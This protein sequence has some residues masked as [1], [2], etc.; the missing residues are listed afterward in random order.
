[1]ACHSSW[2]E[3][4]IGSR[5]QATVGATQLSPDCSL[6][7]WDNELERAVTLPSKEAQNQNRI[8]KVEYSK[9]RTEEEEGGEG[10]RGS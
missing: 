2:L 9:E 8:L 1:M 3:L 4:F 5:D 7:N 10:G 6:T